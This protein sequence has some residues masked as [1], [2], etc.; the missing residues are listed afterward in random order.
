[1]NPEELSEQAEHAHHS[2]QKAIGRDHRGYRSSAGD[3][4]FDESSR[5][6]RRNQTGRQRLWTSG[7]SIRPSTCELISTASRR[8]RLKRRT[9][10]TGVGVHA[11]FMG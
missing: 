1:M 2:G 9:P 8:K 4:Y 5:A 7:I 10:R 6:H 11:R 3:G